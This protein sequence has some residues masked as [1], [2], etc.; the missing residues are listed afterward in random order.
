MNTRTRP[1]KKMKQQTNPKK[2]TIK[3]NSTKTRIGL[4]QNRR[5][6]L[7]KQSTEDEA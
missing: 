4:R 5:M 1:N 3:R 6:I 2:K 7:T